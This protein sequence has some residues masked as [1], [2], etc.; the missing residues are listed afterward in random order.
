MLKGSGTAALLDLATLE[1]SE[2]QDDSKQRFSTIPGRHPSGR[3]V[4]LLPTDAQASLNLAMNL[5]QS[6][7]T[8]VANTAYTQVMQFPAAG[9]VKWRNWG[10]TGFTELGFRKAGGGLRP[11]VLSFCDEPCG[12]L[13]GC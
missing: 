7:E 10:A 6:E 8:E 1:R 12:C 11:D 5:E 3:E 9:S 13:M 2:N 4:L